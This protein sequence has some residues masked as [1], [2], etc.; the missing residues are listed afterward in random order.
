MDALDAILIV[1]VIAAAVHGVRLGAAVQV[2]SFAGALA[3]V[4]IGVVLVLS[5]SPHIHSQLPK[6]FT[7]LLVLILPTAAMWGLGRQLG[8]RAWKKL[9]GNR[10]EGVDAASGAVIAMVGTLV[11][12][13]I[14]SSILVE[15]QVGLVATQIQ[16]SGLIRAVDGALPPV[17]NE[18]ASVERLFSEHGFPLAYLEVRPSAGPVSMPDQRQF[19]TAVRAAAASTVK[20]LGTGCG[21]V[22]QYGSGFVV[23]PGLVVTNAHVV[24]GTTRIDVIDQTEYHPA[25]PVLFDP[26]FDLAVLRVPT[27]TDPALRVDSGY[28]GRGAKAAVLGYPGG[29]G[30]T[31]VPAG[32]VLRFDPPAPDIYGNN[33]TQR[34]IYELQATVRPGNSG[35][36]LVEPNGEVV[37]VVFSRD[38]SNPNVGFALASPG[39][40]ARIQAAE[41]EPA[42]ADVGTGHCI[43]G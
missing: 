27:L 43:S 30:F 33:G 40:E 24:A 6:T 25:T 15:S 7:A 11:V 20:I 28:V 2:L 36:P 18:L 10:F 8:A 13:W 37:G 3:G 35:G 9:R 5:I 23:A 39:V 22:Y 4:A 42:N 38:A 32:V 12:V 34:Q 41:T 31:A 14:L 17:P 21:N 26:E 19:D 1:L 29:H 16:D